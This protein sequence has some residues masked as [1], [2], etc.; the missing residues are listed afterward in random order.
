[1]N[2]DQDKVNITQKKLCKDAVK[3]LPLSLFHILSH[4]ITSDSKYNVSYS[5]GQEGTSNRNLKICL[6]NLS[7]IENN[8][9]AIIVGKAVNAPMKAIND[10]D[11]YINKLKIILQKIK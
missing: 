3:L 5:I 2:N 7:I 10:I 8:N 6:V 4:H 9:N 1:M 11:G